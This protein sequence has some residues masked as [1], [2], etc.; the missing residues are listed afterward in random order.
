MI[1]TPGATPATCGSVA[2]K[3]KRAPEA[4]SRITFGPGVKSDEGT[5][6]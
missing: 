5:K 2:R 3:P 4:V 1:P 6:G